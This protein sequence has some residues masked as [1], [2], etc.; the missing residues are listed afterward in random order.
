MEDAHHM[1]SLQWEQKV[2]W[3]RYVAMNLWPLTT[4]IFLLT[5]PLWPLIDLS[6]DT[7]R[8]C[9]PAEIENDLK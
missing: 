9:V 5:A 4:W 8:R 2:N 6:L 1:K 3:R 7:N